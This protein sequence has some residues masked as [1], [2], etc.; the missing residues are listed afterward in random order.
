M[1]LQVVKSELGDSA[2][3]LAQQG[4]ALRSLAAILWAQSTHLPKELGM[5]LSRDSD[6][7]V[8]RTLASELRDDQRSADVRA[9][10]EADP[11]WSV[12]S[13]VRSGVAKETS[14]VRSVGTGR[15]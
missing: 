3:M 2:T 13:I 7:R 14:H 11:R 10:L 1:A 9:V 4:W 5:I 12:R 8:R 6:G 15:R